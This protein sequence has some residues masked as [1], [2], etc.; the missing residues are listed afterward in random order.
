MQ[1][2]IFVLS[3]V[4]TLF[5]T[6]ESI[7]NEIQWT[8]LNGVLRSTRIESTVV[9]RPPGSHPTQNGTSHDVPTFFVTF[10]G[11]HLKEESLKDWLRSCC[12]P[13][14]S[15]PLSET[16]FALSQSNFWSKK[17][18]DILILNLRSQFLV[19]FGGSLPCPN[20][21]SSHPNF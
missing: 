1:I 11:F 10:V 6:E 20:S 12:T 4:H 9:P 14:S 3:F 16:A 5:I 19:N 18:G 21:S 7:L 8:S 17:L 13:V 15:D 2:S